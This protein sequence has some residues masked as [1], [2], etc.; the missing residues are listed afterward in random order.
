MRGILLVGLHLTLL[1]AAAP[2]LAVWSGQQPG[3]RCTLTGRTVQVCCCSKDGG[4]LYCK[5]AK[6]N[7]DRCCCEPP[8]KLSSR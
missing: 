6:K 2:T 8:Q 7:V 5:L 3:I 4:K 1:V